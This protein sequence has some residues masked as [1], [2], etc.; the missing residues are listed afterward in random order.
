M[1]FL[2][3]CNVLTELSQRHHWFSLRSWT[4]GKTITI[5]R[6]ILCFALAV[7]H[8]R[9]AR[10]TNYTRLWHWYPGRHRCRKWAVCRPFFILGF[11]GNS[12]G[13]SRE[14]IS[15]RTVF[16]KQLRKYCCY[17][18]IFYDQTLKR[19][20]ARQINFEKTTVSFTTT[21]RDRNT[22]KSFKFLN[23]TV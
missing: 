14:K 6:S 8:H 10:Q 23:F 15:K 3:G 5:I 20:T 1:L 11:L 21:V 22:F 12:N 4:T 16:L 13:A 7:Y 2:N 17:R 9:H 18:C 19:D